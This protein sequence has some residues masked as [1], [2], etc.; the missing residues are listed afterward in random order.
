MKCILSSL[1]AG[2]LFFSAAA[3]PVARTKHLFIITIDGFRWQEVFTGADPLLV[4]NPDYVRD[5]ALTRGMYWDSSAELR[6]QKLLP[7]FWG[8]LAAKVD[9]MATGSWGIK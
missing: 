2:M 9:Y 4:T 6:R 5:T 7:F 8:T 3:Q 1:V